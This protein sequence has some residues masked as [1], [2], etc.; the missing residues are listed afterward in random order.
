LSTFAQHN[1]QPHKYQ[2]N[3]NEFSL[4]TIARNRLHPCG[5]HGIENLFGGRPGADKKP[6]VMSFV[7]ATLSMTESIASRDIADDAKF[8]EGLAKVIDGTV[9]CLN[10]SIWAKANQP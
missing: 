10:A 6:A 1:P 8:K 9:E 2:E 5:F 7:Q 4:S 3:S